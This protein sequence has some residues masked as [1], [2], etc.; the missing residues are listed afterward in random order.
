MSLAPLVDILFEQRKEHVP[1]GIQ[2]DSDPRR[3]FIK[4]E[5]TEQFSPQAQT[6]HAISCFP[7]S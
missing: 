1:T 7:E 2:R 4:G 5:N 6:N 3:R